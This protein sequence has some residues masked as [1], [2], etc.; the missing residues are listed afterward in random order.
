MPACRRSSPRP[1][2]VSA[3]TCVKLG[4][5]APIKASSNA[6]SRPVDIARMNRPAAETS[7][8]MLQH[9]GNPVDW[10]ARGPEAFE[11]AKA[12]DKPII[13]SIGYSACHWCH[14]MEHE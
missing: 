10:Y 1:S 14:V 3:T 7:P 8:Y 4:S 5:P 6:A 13:L 11:A 9:A 2:P 12:A